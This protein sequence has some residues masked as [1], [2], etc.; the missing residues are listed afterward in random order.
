MIGIVLDLVVSILGRTYLVCDR[1]RR[2]R[3]FTLTCYSFLHL[4]HDV[5]TWNDN[6]RDPH[7]LAR[8]GDS[9]S[10]PI[11]WSKLFVELKLST[12]WSQ[13]LHFQLQGFD[14]GLAWISMVIT[15]VIYC[16]D[17]SLQW[18]W[19]FGNYSAYN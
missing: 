12:T 16:M 11:Q 19:D 15:Y 5:A 8:W 4:Y 6:L 2:T 14:E 10:N 3:I 18:T 13:T 17:L 1:L 7:L 9:W